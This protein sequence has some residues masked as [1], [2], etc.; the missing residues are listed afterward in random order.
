MLDGGNHFQL[1]GELAVGDQGLGQ[2]IGFVDHEL[3]GTRFFARH[4]GHALRLL[5]HVLLKGQYALF[6]FRESLDR[7]GVGVP[8]GGIGLAIL[9]YRQVHG[10]FV[11]LQ[12]IHNVEKN[13]G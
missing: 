9:L 10:Q 12:I 11:V 13:S 3:P 8:L 5:P 4:P 7:N 6:K 1:V 2:H